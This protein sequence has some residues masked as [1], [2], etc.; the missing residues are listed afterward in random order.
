[1]AKN[2]VQFQK[3]LSLPTFLDAYGT[4]QQCEQTLY[5]WRW[6]DGFVCP[7]C[8]QRS[9]CKLNSR[10]LYQCNHCHHQTSVIS[11][12]IF[13][14]TKLA[15]TT[16]FLAIYLLTQSK[17]GIS[18]LALKR[19][20]GVSY[21]TAWSIKHKLMQVMK[22][23]DDSQPLIGTIQIDD[24]Y[25]GG[26]RHGGKRGR[27]AAAKVPIVAAVATNEKGHPIAMRMSKVRAFTQAEIAAWSRKHLVASDTVVSDG[28][29]CFPAVTAAGCTHI[30]IV[31]GGGPESVK[32]EE[33]TWVNTLIGNVKN[34][35]HGTY[36]AVSARHLPR[37]LAEFN[38]RFNRR[39]KLEDMVPRL[40]YVAVR[41]PPMPMRLLTIAEVRW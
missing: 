25:W 36:H 5:R 9:H 23:R 28:L 27:G 32:H 2:P 7:Q 22:E 30:A 14:S 21:R 38:Y 19:L 17:T 15:L 34:S 12:T 41:T 3:G 31:T 40:G 1:M 39:F 6:P 8:Q 10:K 37:Y 13:A 11:G 20:L 29:N 26:E 4:E 16:W 35:L 33:F 24:A 18:A